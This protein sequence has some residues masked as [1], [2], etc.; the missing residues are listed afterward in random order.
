MR[1]ESFN[2]EIRLL[3][4]ST[5][6]WTKLIDQLTSVDPS[7]RLSADEAIEL[8]EEI[9]FYHRTGLKKERVKQKIGS[10]FKF[11]F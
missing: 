1:L 10:D 3:G 7:Q 8:L 2:P 11:C 5:K 9:E 4:P 6:L